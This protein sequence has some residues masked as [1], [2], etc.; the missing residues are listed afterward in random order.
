MAAL[1]PQ[2]HPRRS[3]VPTLTQPC[4]WSFFLSWFSKSA[5]PGRGGLQGC[6]QGP[7]GYYMGQVLA[8]QPHGHG[9]LFAAEVG[10]PLL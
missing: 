6:L 10:A 4:A 2:Q 1:S 9:C 8:A 7:A 3:H 5:G